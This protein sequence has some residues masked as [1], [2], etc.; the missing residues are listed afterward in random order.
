MDIF[1][2]AVY[3]EKEKVFFNSQWLESLPNRLPELLPRDSRFA[4]SAPCLP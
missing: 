3:P 1:C 2:M 4:D